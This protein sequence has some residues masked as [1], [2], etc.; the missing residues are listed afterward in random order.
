MS[1]SIRHPLLLLLLL[2]DGVGADLSSPPLQPLSELE[3][4]PSCS[5]ERLCDTTTDLES[6]LAEVT[7]RLDRLQRRMDSRLGE[8]EPIPPYSAAVRDCS[9]LPAG[10]AS[11][12]HLLRPE[13]GRPVPAYC[14]LTSAGG[15]WTLLLRRAD[16]RPRRD[17]YLGWHEYKWGFGELDAEFWWGL[18]NLWRLT[19]LLDRR[20]ELRV[21]L[22]DFDGG[23]RHALY[24]GFRI[25]SEEDGYRLSAENYTGDAGDSLSYH[26]GQR[27]S[28]K[29]RDHDSHGVKECANIFKGGWWYKS[30]FKSNLNGQ[31]LSGETPPKSYGVVWDEWLGINYSLK[32]VEMKI[33]PTKK[34]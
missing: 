34:L 21:D 26:V 30:C 19:S 2:T 6:R 8:T 13:L 10:S 28:T 4:T 24:Q 1:V 27:F 16:I 7:A 5:L 15:G 29:D 14:D 3:V 12:V 31:Y 32:M 25:S 20:Y 23:R 22:E 18:E 9:D 17:F 11:G 33:R